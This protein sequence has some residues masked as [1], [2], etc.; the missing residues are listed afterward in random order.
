MFRHVCTILILHEC[1]QVCSPFARF[2]R[3]KQIDKLCTDLTPP[4]SLGNLRNTRTGIRCLDLNDSLHVVC[5]LLWKMVSLYANKYPSYIKWKVHELYS[6]R[7][8]MLRKA[9]NSFLSVC[10]FVSMERGM[11]SQEFS[12]HFV[13]WEILPKICFHIPILVKIEKKYPAFFV[14][15]C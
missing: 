4:T 1:L 13:F 3:D 14:N 6:A 5:R 15:T 12:W 9:K 8:N 11:A 10:L 2:F 7:S